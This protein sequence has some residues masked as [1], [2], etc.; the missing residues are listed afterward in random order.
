MWRYANGKIFLMAFSCGVFLRSRYRR[1]VLLLTSHYR[2]GVRGLV[3]VGFSLQK[4]T[5]F[6]N[7]S[8]DLE[9]VWFSGFYHVI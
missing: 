1:V 6:V 2:R 9:Y 3:R 7:V 8:D 5:M 4:V